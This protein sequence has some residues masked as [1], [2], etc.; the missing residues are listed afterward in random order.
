MDDD[1]AGQL[2]VDVMAKVFVARLPVRYEKINATLAL[3][4]ANPAAIENWVE[5]HRLLE[6]L[7]EA[8]GAFGRDALA[9]Q[10]GMIELL[11]AD[12]LAQRARSA[13]DVD[14]VARLLAIM[15]SST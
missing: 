8:A 4:R 2:K 15:Q 1:K 13:A 6:S 11:L 3:C 12:M 14:E 10:A 5:L 7:A 9:E